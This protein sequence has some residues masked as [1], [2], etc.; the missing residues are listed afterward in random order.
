[1]YKKLVLSGGGINGI[2]FI[3]I[4]KYLEEHNLLKNINVFVGTS[5]GSLINT[6]IILNYKSL[7]I[8]DFILK[9]KFSDII[10]FNVV[11]LFTDFGIDDGILFEILIKCFIR[12]K[13]KRD[14]IT[15][16]ELYNITKKKNIIISCNINKNKSIYIDHI[17]HPNLK[18]VTALKMS[19]CIPF[20]FKPILYK[21][22]LYVD[23]SMLCHFGIN[24]F[25]DNDKEVLGI[26]LKNNNIIKKNNSSFDNYISLLLN[27]YINLNIY[28][29]KNIIEIDYIYNVL[30]FSIKKQEKKNLIDIG[31]NKI[32]NYLKKNN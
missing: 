18:L 20:Y 12:N 1:M 31:Y 22:D 19:T 17:S 15:L 13:L 4:L 30:E 8:E 3:G 2:I 11:N 32:Y 29:N 23:G 16:I 26:L 6:L 28:K 9:F 24:L 27:M 21:N 25:K 10:K 5:I 14:N 7:E